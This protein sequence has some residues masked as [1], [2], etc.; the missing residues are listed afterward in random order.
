MARFVHI[1]DRRTAASILRSGLKASRWYDPR[2]VFCIPVVP[3]HARTFQWARELRRWNDK[4]DL[5]VFFVLD[6]SETVLVG[7]YGR[8]RDP[9]TA[10]Q[11][12][13][14]FRSSDDPS[15]YEVVVPR[16]IAPGEIKSM[17]PAPR[18]TGWRYEPGSNGRRPLWPYPGTRNAAKRRRALE[19]W[20]NRP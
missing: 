15:G 17:G 4:A 14:F 18:V 8:E 20:Y 19:D 10:A 5:A 13:A 1:A 3:D 12:H 6:D 2:G 7:R 9:M 16:N 11:A